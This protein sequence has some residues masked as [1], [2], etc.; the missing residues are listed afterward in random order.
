MGDRRS[1]GAGLADAGLGAEQERSPA[2]GQNAAQDEGLDSSPDGLWKPQGGGDR[3][4]KPKASQ[5][6]GQAVSPAPSPAEDSLGPQ[7]A[8]P[9]ALVLGIAQDAGY[10]QAGCRGACCAPAWRDVSLR[11]HAACL[12]LVDPQSGG[13]WII[14]ATPDL[15]AQLRMLDERFPPDPARP[16]PGLDGIALSHGHIGHYP[17]LW[18]LGAE[19]MAAQGVPVYAMPRMADFL[20]GNLPWSDLIAGGHVL[21]EPMRAGSALELAPGLS[22]TPLVVPHRDEHTETVGFHVEGPTRSLLYIPDIDGWEHW[23][24]AGER[25]EDWLERVDVALV[26]GTFFDESE[27]PGRDLTKIPHPTVAATMERLAGLPEELRGRLR[28]TH[29]NHSNPLLRAGGAAGRAARRRVAAA[30]SGV[31]V[32]GEVVRL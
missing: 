21:L 32:E 10:P 15:K 9:A 17:G 27:L 2:V 7:A 8:G 4:A 23:E 19:A 16:A 14:D 1:G 25:I 12:A 22:L 30:G 18:N 13:R 20:R 24:R 3:D 11:R 29:L 26:D 5:A 28:F 6:L 31:A